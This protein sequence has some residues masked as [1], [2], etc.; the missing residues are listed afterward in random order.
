MREIAVFVAWFILINSAAHAQQDVQ[1]SLNTDAGIFTVSKTPGCKDFL[2]MSIK[3]WN[4]M[5]AGT[6]Y[7]S[8]KLPDGKSLFLCIEIAERKNG[9]CNKG[10][11]FGCSILDC[12]NYRKQTVQQ[13]NNHN[14]FCVIA[15]TRDSGNSI[16][17]VFNDDV[18][19]DSLNAVSR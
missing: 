11:G 3:T 7:I 9:F 15:V 1:F 5:V 6:K 19:W 17:V 16:R 14:R 2:L 13:V 18:D 8:S 10:I 4:Q 12:P